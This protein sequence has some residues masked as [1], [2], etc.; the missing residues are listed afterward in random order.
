[1]GGIFKQ[2]ILQRQNENGTS[3]LRDLA[4]VLSKADNVLLAQGPFASA[5]I[6]NRN[7]QKAHTWSD[8][9]EKDKSGPHP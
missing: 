4:A 9:A 7:C 8:A 2:Q 3:L 1:M 6:E 5:A